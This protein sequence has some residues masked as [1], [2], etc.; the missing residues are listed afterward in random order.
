MFLDEKKP[1]DYLPKDNLRDLEDVVHYTPANSDLHTID[2]SGR[3]DV[4]E[5]EKYDDEVSIVSEIFSYIKILVAAVILAL[6]VNNFII[7]NATVPTGSMNNTIMEED[8]LI[9][10][11]LAYSFS[12]PKRGDIIIFD[13]PD[14]PTQKY[15]KRIIGLPGDIVEIKSDDT[16]AS[17]YVNSKLLNEPYIK[18]PMN[19]TL[20]STYVVP[21]GH[22]FVLG[23]NRNDSKDSRYWDNTFVPEDTIL[24]KALV[25]YYSEFKIFEQPKYE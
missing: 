1:E 5:I 19:P 2:I 11:R 14:D 24:A 9:G 15:V 23:D 6:I 10:L 17:V 18:E 22:Y 16:S 7:I 21:V 3:V 8:R 13:Y 20:S 12:E 25:K 4:K